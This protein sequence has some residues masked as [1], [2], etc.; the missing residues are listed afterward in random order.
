MTIINFEKVY[1]IGSYIFLRNQ[2]EF[3]FLYQCIFM[4]S[5]NIIEEFLF[6]IILMK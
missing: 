5:K 1:I 3:K 2:N 6:D 4:S